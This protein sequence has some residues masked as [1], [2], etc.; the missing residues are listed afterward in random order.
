MSTAGP[1]R[2]LL[3][4]CL[5][6]SARSGAPVLSYFFSVPHRP[7]WRRPQLVSGFR[8]WAPWSRRYCK[9][10]A[11]HE[12]LSAFSTARRTKRTSPASVLGTW[13]PAWCRMSTLY[14]TPRLCPNASLPL[15]SP[16]SSPM[17]SCPS[18]TAC[19]TFCRRSTTPTRPL[20]PRAPFWTFSLTAPASP[21]RMLFGSGMNTNCC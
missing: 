17:A 19:A 15:P 12:H 7:P 13:L 8:N 9:H 11:Q 14:I 2:S 21:P 18:Q 6:P 10:L 3:D 1:S 20:A 5:L 4:A 16:S